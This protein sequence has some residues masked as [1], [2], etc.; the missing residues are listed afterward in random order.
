MAP[1]PLIVAIGY[2]YSATHFILAAANVVVAYLASQKTWAILSATVPWVVFAL[3]GLVS[4]WV[5][6]RAVI[7]VYQRR[8]LKAV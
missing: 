8:A 1:R 2:V 5:V 6:R 7:A 4:W 3:L